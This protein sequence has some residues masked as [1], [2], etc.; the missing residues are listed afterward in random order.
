MS[1]TVI[2][3]GTESGN[4]EMV[5]EDLEAEIA[6]EVRVEDMTDFEL[7]A[8]SADDFYIIVCS[9]HGDGELPTGARPFY[10]ALQAETPDL[11]DVTY[12][13]FGLG[14]SSYETYSHGSEIIDE[15]LTE[16]G[17]HRVGV[18]GR[19]DASDGSLPNDT[20]IEWVRE[21]VA[22]RVAA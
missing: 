17:A 7:D 22:G 3:F 19:H 20:A 2:L 1:R 12:A 16:L 5:A 11:A 8:L 14:D 21:L 6:G 13:V 18:Y 10:A 4:A 9:T 15:K